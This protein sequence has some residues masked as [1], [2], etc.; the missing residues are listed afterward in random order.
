MLGESADLENPIK[1]A[2]RGVK[3]KKK[4]RKTSNST[5]YIITT[6]LN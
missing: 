1:L 3:R 4:M 5:P 6:L 2:S